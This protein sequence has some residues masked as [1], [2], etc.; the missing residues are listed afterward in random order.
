MS[1]QLPP[2]MSI[3]HNKDTRKVTLSILDREQRKQR[4]MWGMST[5]TT[6]SPVDSI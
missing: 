4:E 1:V 6:L 5:S 3:Q 2:Y